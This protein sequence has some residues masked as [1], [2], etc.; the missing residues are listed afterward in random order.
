MCHACCEVCHLVW[1]VTRDEVIMD[2]GYSIEES[3]PKE[4]K[5]CSQMLKLQKYRPCCI[6]DVATGLARGNVM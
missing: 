4:I 6:A 3:V 1:R 2:D 5:A